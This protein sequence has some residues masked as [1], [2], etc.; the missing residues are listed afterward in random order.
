MIE[1]IS[2]ELELRPL[3]TIIVRKACELLNA[4]RGSIGL[5]DDNAGAVRI[6]AAYRMPPEELGAVVSRGEGLAG[7]VYETGAPVILG[8]YGFVHKPS[9]KGMDEDV[10]VGMPIKW[11]GAT[12]G[13]FGIGAD[14]AHEFTDDDL[15]TLELFARHA[16]IAI[17]NAKSY[18]RERRRAVRLRAAN[19]IGESALERDPAKIVSVAE[20]A[21]RTALDIKCVVLKRTDPAP[22]G[23]LL[24][25]LCH[26]ASDYDRLAVLSPNSLSTE[27]RLTFETL[28]SQ[29]GLA[30]ERAGLMEESRRQLEEIKLLYETS[31]RVS[32]AM[33]LKGVVAAYLSYVAARD[34][35]RC[36]IGL[37]ETD[38]D[39]NEYLSVIG[40][41]TQDGGIS[42]DP[43]RF[44]INDIRTR[45]QFDDF[46][47]VTSAN[48]HEDPSMPDGVKAIM[49]ES[50]GVALAS[51][52]LVVRNERIGLIALTFD[53]EHEWTEDDLR[54]YR[55]TGA[56]LAAIIKNRLDHRKLVEN[57]QRLAALDERRKLARD[58]HDSVSQLIF[59]MGLM[60]QSVSAG[61][62]ANR[63]EGEAR[64]DR[65]LEITQL[66]RAEM[67]ALLA[68]LRD[69]E[70]D[71]SGSLAAIASPANAMAF[72]GVRADRIQRSGNPAST[73]SASADVAR[74]RRLDEPRRRCRDTTIANAHA[75]SHPS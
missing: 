72:S 52:P 65:L 59:S 73:T 58:L 61:Y 2:G 36:D 20:T 23:A 74:S 71:E 19:I 9:L 34:Q 26:E 56:L 48:V 11:R 70:G 57:D 55:I 49:R 4:D 42:N 75:K 68:E 45:Y 8:R 63:E 62:E 21:L 66:A 29:I 50:G 10:V 64:V 22:D 46:E 28:A 18:E 5:V 6:E 12:I 51:F 43:A 15:E 33:D 30:L 67:K 38:K 7:T 1:V 47:L 27:D 44:L 31:R 25:P 32:T 35:Y 60:A 37:T 39:D 41:R 17:N 53:E 54:P 3:L 40:R 14:A 69:P 13:T 24:L 16:A